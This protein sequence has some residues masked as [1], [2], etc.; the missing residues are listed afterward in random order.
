[1]FRVL[2]Q[3]VSYSRKIHRS[4]DARGYATIPS[5]EQ[6]VG[7][8]EGD[9]EVTSESGRKPRDEKRTRVLG[10]G[11]PLGITGPIWVPVKQEQYR[12]SCQ[13]YAKE[14]P[15]NHAIK[16]GINVSSIMRQHTESKDWSRMSLVFTGA[17]QVLTWSHSGQ[18][19]LH[20]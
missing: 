10:E 2:C 17:M 15:T 20:I 9:Q 18:S 7:N 14:E 12:V 5:L 3:W 19:S 8:G 4:G 6:I 1:M 16:I 11:R 13:T